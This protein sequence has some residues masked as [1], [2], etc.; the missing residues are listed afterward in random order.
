MREQNERKVGRDREK[1]VKEEETVHFNALL[2]EKVQNVSNVR[3]SIYLMP[4]VF[5][6]LGT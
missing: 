5:T 2:A 3:T 1:F 6:I 4:V